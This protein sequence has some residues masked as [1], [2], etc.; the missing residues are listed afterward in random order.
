MK[1]LAFLSVLLAS[2][3]AADWDQCATDLYVASDFASLAAPYVIEWENAVEA[4]VQCFD[5]AQFSEGALEHETT[6]QEESAAAQAAEQSM[7][8]ATNAATSAVSTAVMGCQ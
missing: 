2:T 4:E 7:R 8:E 5:M 6:C 1:K 3:A